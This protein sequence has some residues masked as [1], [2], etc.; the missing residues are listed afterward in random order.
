MNAMPP[1]TMICAVFGF[2]ATAFE[3]GY[4]QESGVFLR[5]SPNFFADDALRLVQ[6]LA[7]MIPL[8]LFLIPF[9]VS[10]YAWWRWRIELLLH[11]D[12]RSAAHF[13]RMFVKPSKS[14]KFSD[15]KKIRVVDSQ[16]YK[17]RMYASLDVRLI[18]FTP[19]LLLVHAL[20]LLLYDIKFD[21]FTGTA[22]VIW[23]V[24]RVCLPVA[25]SVVLFLTLNGNIK[26]PFAAAFSAIGALLA[27]V[28]MHVAC[29]VVD[30]NFTSA[31]LPEVL[32]YLSMAAFVMSLEFP[33]VEQAAEQRIFA[34]TPEAFCLNWGDGDIPEELCEY[35]ESTACIVLSFMTFGI[36]QLMWMNRLCKKIHLLAGEPRKSTKE[37]V[38]IV[39]VP[40]YILYWMRKNGRKISENAKKLNIQLADNSAF[41]ILFSLCGLSVIAVSMMQKDFNR[42]S[43][44]LNRTVSAAALR[45]KEDKKNIPAK[46]K[47]GGAEAQNKEEK[48][49]DILSL[50]E[51]LRQLRAMDILTDEEFAE[52]KQKLLSRM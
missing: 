5:M 6:I 22:A 14:G 33:F 17:N 30:R 52:K 20:Y 49:I 8:S 36:Y 32:F 7:L 42:I 11:S 34:G 44:R 41:Y 28:A 13:R 10:N 45:N 31:F 47:Q 12:S 26:K 15:T 1:F 46:A 24:C 19:A 18:L 29:A 37:M 27:S 16:T 25:F 35:E 38:C 48:T 23:I 21:L 2:F 3:L 50:L 51:S 4:A 40:F 39:L 43:R 9:V